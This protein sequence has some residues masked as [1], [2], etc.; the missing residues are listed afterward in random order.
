MKKL[1]GNK[2]TKTILLGLLIG[3]GIYLLVTC[4]MSVVGSIEFLTEKIYMF[5]KAGTSMFQA[6]YDNQLFSMI[7]TCLFFLFISI[8]VVIEVVALIKQLKQ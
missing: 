5:E 7:R 3:L 6:M 4:I 8:S 2:I 1:S